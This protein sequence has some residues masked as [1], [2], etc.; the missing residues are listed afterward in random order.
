MLNEWGKLNRENIRNLVIDEASKQKEELKELLKRRLIYLKMDACI[1]HRLRT[2][3]SKVT[4]LFKFGEIFLLALPV[5]SIIFLRFWCPSLNRCRSVS[6]EVFIFMEHSSYLSNM[7]S[8][9]YIYNVVYFKYKNLIL[10]TDNHDFWQ[11]C[12]FNNKSKLFN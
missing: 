3:A 9:N 1:R 10:Y 2:P 6:I 5:I 7:N 4:L 12:F 11:L 8:L